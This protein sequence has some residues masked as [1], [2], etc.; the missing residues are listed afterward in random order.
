[1]SPDGREQDVKE[2]GMERRGG[3]TRE[4][5]D[6]RTLP[7]LQITMGQPMMVSK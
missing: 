6:G 7:P 2:G 3:M 1:M 4:G 5:K